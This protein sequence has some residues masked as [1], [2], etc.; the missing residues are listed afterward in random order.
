[1]SEKYRV[2]YQNTNNQ[3]DNGLMELGFET[4]QQAQARC[5]HLATIWG[6]YTF[7]VVPPYTPPAVTHEGD[8]ETQ[9]GSRPPGLGDPLDEVLP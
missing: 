1:M 4:A 3:A 2:K 8:L 6:M 9:A 7:T 5:D